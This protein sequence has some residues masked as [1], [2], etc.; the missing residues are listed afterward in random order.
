MPI[1]IFRNLL[2]SSAQAVIGAPLQYLPQLVSAVII[3]VIGWIIAI[4]VERA[5]R[6]VFKSVS[7]ID[8]SLRSLGLEK[9]TRRAGVRVDLGYFFGVIFKVF[10]I[11]IAFVAAFD[12]LGLQN[13]NQFLTTEVLSYI[14]NVI[15]SAVVLVIGLLVAN[16]V[17]GLVHRATSAARVSGG[18]AVTITKWAIIVFSVLVA[19]GELGVASD[20]IRS[21]IVGV[22]ASFS[23]GL[24]LAFGLG[25]QQA[26]ADFLQRIRN[27]LNQS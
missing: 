25:G 16:F 9:V 20:I 13:I 1:E 5:I 26:A 24:G 17:A 6:S 22:I 2:S 12:V 19:L 8:E 27:D 15:S 3:V 21:L 11:V 18:L 4:I 14:P 7:F 23:L 10:I